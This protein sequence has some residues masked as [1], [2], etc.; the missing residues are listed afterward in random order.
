M[1]VIDGWRVIESVAGWP[2]VVRMIARLRAPYLPFA[3]AGRVTLS[4]DGGASGRDGDRAPQDETAS[5]FGG[6]E[7]QRPAEER[8]DVLLKPNRHV[9]RV[10]SRVDL[11]RVRDP[12][13]I[14]H[15]VQLSGVD[16]Q[17]V[18]IADVDRDGAILT[19]AWD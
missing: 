15:V 9:A 11:E 6:L 5:L 1:A 8:H 3:R 17:P 4:A 13:L 16:A 10:G 12:V 14:E 7:R 18:L 2:I 19:Q